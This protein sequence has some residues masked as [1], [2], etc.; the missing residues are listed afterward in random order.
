MKQGALPAPLVLFPELERPRGHFRRPPI[1]TVT[2]THHSCLAARG[3]ARIARAPSIQES[4]TGATFPQMQGGPAPERS[5]P[6]D[7]DMRFCRHATYACTWHFA[8]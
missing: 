2:P 7:C 3:R 1:V 5:R 4:Y 8:W 6:D